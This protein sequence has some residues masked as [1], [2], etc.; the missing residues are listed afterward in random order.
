VGRHGYDPAATT[1]PSSGASLLEL[2]QNLVNMMTQA[3]RRSGGM[4]SAWATSSRGGLDGA[5]DL[6]GEIIVKEAI[7]QSKFYFNYDTQEYAYRS[8]ASL[9]QGDREPQAHRRRGQRVLSR[10]R[11]KIYNGDR[12]KWL[13]VAY[14]LRPS[15]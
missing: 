7:D 11:D 8:P 4:C 3:R 2:R 14:G 6:H 10:A 13:K 5:D 9:R 15:P 12:T 1:A